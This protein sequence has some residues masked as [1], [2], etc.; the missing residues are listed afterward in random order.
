MQGLEQMSTK[1][2]IDWERLHRKPETRE[3]AQQEIQ[4]ERR[5]LPEIDWSLLTQI[6]PKQGDA[7]TPLDFGSRKETKEQDIDWSML[8]KSPK[9]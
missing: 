9:R 7:H 8:T 2:E 4:Q 3:D 1:K 5:L 6:N